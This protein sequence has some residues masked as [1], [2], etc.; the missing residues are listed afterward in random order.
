MEQNK[1]ALR[2]VGW[3]DGHE[4]RVSWCEGARAGAAGRG[5]GGIE[6]V[7][8]GLDVDIAV[9]NKRVCREG[10][11]ILACKFRNQLQSTNGYS[12]SKLTRRRLSRAGSTSPGQEHLVKVTNLSHCWQ[13]FPHLPRN[14]RQVLRRLECCSRTRSRPRSQES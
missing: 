7:I 5:R 4:Q 13:Q 12:K 11:G 3:H 8:D 2:R 10:D 9:Q 1:P 14:R 6:L